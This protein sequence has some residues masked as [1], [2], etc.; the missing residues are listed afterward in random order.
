VPAQFQA[1]HLLPLFAVVKTTH[2][3]CVLKRVQRI[4]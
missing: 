3:N 4:L 1:T 2:S